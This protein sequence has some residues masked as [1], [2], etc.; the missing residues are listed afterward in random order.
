MTTAMMGTSFQVVSP[1]KGR[2]PR[3]EDF[4]QHPMINNCNAANIAKKDDLRNISILQIRRLE[5]ENIQA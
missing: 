2:A 4:I 5:L 3:L 1:S